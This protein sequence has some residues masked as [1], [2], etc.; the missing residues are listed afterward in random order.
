MESNTV[1]RINS[2]LFSTNQMVHIISS[3][4][5]KLFQPIESLKTSKPSLGV[6]NTP[7]CST[8]NFKD[9]KAQR[10]FMVHDSYRDVSY[11][12]LSCLLTYLVIKLTYYRS[13]LNFCFIEAIDWS[14]RVM[15]CR[16]FH[17]SATRF[18]KKFFLMS[19]RLYCFINF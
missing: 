9:W 13:A 5:K 7:V 18:E 4:R 14:F 12:F 16:L 11:C 15:S 17:V 6:D 19:V 8:Q 2:H 1:V 3:M 10:T